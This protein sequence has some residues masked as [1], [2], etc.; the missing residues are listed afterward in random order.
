MWQHNLI[1][2]GMNRPIWRRWIDYALFSG[3][4]TA[5]TDADPAG[6]KRVKWTPHAWPYLHPVQDIQAQTAE[7]RSGL[8]SRSEKISERGYDPEAIDAEQAAD[9]AR[10]DE[11][12]LVHD[13]DPRKTSVAGLTQART[14]GS[15]LPDTDP[16]DDGDQQP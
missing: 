10:A 2:F 15:A 5:P 1:A 9:N 7:I 12:G 8:A 3:A 4:L 13:S 6:L 14:P 16:S 11:L